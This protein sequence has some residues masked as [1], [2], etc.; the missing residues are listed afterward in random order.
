MQKSY[1][2]IQ[3]NINSNENPIDLKMGDVVSLGAK[4]ENDDDGQWENWIYC[5]S[6]RTGKKGWTPVQI[7]KI[8]NQSAIVTT[9]YI[10]TEMTVSSGDILIGENELNGWIWCVR[11]ADGESGWVPQ[12]CLKQG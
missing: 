6:M 4:S 1:I 5:V 8:D 2:V 9:D 10:A 7:L 11:K 12:N 3:E